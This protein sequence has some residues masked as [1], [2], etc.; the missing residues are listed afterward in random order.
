M[1]KEDILGKDYDEWSEE[2]IEYMKE[3]D[4]CCSECGWILSDD[5]FE[6]E[7]EDRGSFWG[8]PCSENIIIGY[9]CSN[10][11]HKESF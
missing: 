10:C 6:S 1:D 4:D 9:N 11:G 7:Y 3:Q 5:D 2:E 8:S